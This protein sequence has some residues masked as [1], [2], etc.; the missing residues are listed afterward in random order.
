MKAQKSDNYYGRLLATAW[1]FVS[2]GFGGI[3]LLFFPLM[4]LMMK[5]SQHDKAVT[6]RKIIHKLLR[7]FICQMKYLGI[8]TYE[9]HGLEKLGPGQLIIA[10]HPTFLDVVFLIS[11]IENANCIV[12][13]S[14]F[15]NPFTCGPLHA[16]GYIPNLDGNQLLKDCIE[17]LKAGDSIII[18]P[19]GTR[20]PTEGLPKMQRGAA[21]IALATGIQ[22]TMITIQC[23]TSFLS[24]GVKWYNIPLCRPH[25]VFKLTEMNDISDLPFN[26]KSAR[27][28]TDMF[29]NHFFAEELKREPRTGT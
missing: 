9:T 5:G 26:P 2:Y 27:K 8:F 21:N 14:L 10:N 19:E 15:K 4:H 20:T 11:F 22:P 6:S 18:F 3:F 28:L 23:S 1:S 25:L 24:K 12:K 29:M 17:S 7:L 13:Y 16:A